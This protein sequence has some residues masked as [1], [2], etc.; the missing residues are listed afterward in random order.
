MD[1]DKDDPVSD[2]EPDNFQLNW[3]ETYEELYIDSF[4]EN[5]DPSHNLGPN[6]SELDLFLLFCDDSML[7]KIFEET[8][9]YASQNGPDRK[10]QDTTREEIS[11]FIGTWLVYFINND[12]NKGLF[13][14]L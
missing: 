2:T 8:N 6:S 14:I 9:R 10:L 11:T 5:T 13:S 7:D 12:R 4:V 1:S 3:H